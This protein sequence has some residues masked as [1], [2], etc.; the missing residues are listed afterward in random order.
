MKTINSSLTR[1]ALRGFAAAICLVGASAHAITVKVKVENTSD[2]DGLWFTPVFFGFHDGSF[3][4]FDPG[5][6]ATSSI[7]KLAE[8][9]DVS[10]L[11]SDLSG[12]SGSKG[13]VLRQDNSGMPPGVLFAPGESNY[14]TIDLDPTLN[15][16]LSYASMILPSNDAFI[17]NATPG[18]ALFDVLGNFNGS[19]YIDI[20]GSNI[21]DA[22][23]EENDFLGQPFDTTMGIATDTFGGSVSLLGQPG[24]DAFKGQAIPPAGLTV[25]DNLSINDQIARISIYEVPTQAV[26]DSTQYIGFLGAF[27]IIGFRLISKKRMGK[28]AA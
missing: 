2:R 23:T 18:L 15:R 17:G 22:G 20:L 7:E 5:V 1:A 21:W 26:P 6:A 25:S 28:D 10:G 24:L 8:G 4:S 12:V 13:H 11:L 9:G 19:Q 27:A 3:D 16:Y 14:F